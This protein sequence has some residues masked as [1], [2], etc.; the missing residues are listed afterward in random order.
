MG[1]GMSHGTERVYT[2]FF[3]LYIQDHRPPV[4]SV[5]KSASIK[6]SD[7]LSDVGSSEGYARPV[8]RM[9]VY[10]PAL[11]PNTADVYLHTKV[12]HY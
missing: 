7:D 2:P 3:R 8:S 4:C 6:I 9:N 12:V 5:K 11:S 10:F 1:H